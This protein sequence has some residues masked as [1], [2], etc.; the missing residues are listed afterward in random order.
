MALTHKLPRTAILMLRGLEGCGLSQ[1]SRMQRAYYDSVGATCDIFAL[2]TKIGRPDTSGDLPVSFFDWAGRANIVSSLNTYDIVLVFSVPDVKEP[3]EVKKNYV[4]EILDKIRV[5]KVMMNHDHH[6]QTFKRNADFAAAIESC[7]L[8]MAHALDANPS[9]FITWMKKNGVSKKPIEKIDIFFHIPF[10]SHLINYEQTD[11]KKRVIHASRAVAWKRASLVLD[12]QPRLAAKGFVT[13]MIGFERSLAGY[14]QILNYEKTLDFYTTQNFIKPV[15]SWSAFSKAD[16][17]SKLMDFID[18]SPQ[19]PN[20][21]YV[22]GAYDYNKGIERVSKSAFASQPRTFEHNKLSYGNTFIEYQGIE[23]AL[24]SVPFYHRHFLDN[25]TV[26]GTTTPLSSTGI[27]LSID[28]N[29]A[30]Y[31]SGGPK[32]INPDAFV[33]QLERIWSDPAEYRTYRK[34]STEFMKK[35]FDSSRVV[36]MMDRIS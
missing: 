36:G 16:L 1:F 10:V 2:Q 8:V 17:N 29:N 22:L 21:M 3:D 11:R 23:A 4:S 12:L 35:Y 15:N 31:K 26:P 19:D 7:D 13:E 6:S 33:D 9:G 20:K 28:D 14:S 34:N 18:S 5:R 32:V 30:T 25:V 27:F 24:L